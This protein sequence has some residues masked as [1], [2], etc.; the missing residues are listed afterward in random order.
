M[1]DAVKPY[2][3][4]A[5]TRGRA[6]SSAVVSKSIEL[7]DTA[8]QKAGVK[9]EDLAKL[10]GIPMLCALVA[11][12][13]N[14]ALLLAMGNNAW[15]KATALSAGQPFTAYLS[16][17]SVKFGTPMNPSADNKF[18]CASN[19]DSCEL[20]LLCSAPDDPAL[21][22]N[23]LPKNTPAEAW[24][25]AAKAGA[26]AMTFLSLGFVPGLAAAG[27]TFL[28]AAKDI[29]SFMPLILK[30][31]DMGFKLYWQK[32][33]IVGCWG[34]LWA[35]MFFSMLVYAMMIPDTLGWGLVELEASFGLLRFAFIIVSIFGAILASNLFTLWT[36]ENVIE[37]WME[38]T[39][40]KMFT[41]KKALYLELML[42]LALYLFMSISLVDWS[43]LLIVLAGYYLDAK[44]WNFLLMYLVL[45]AISI[46]FDLVHLASLPSFSNMTPGESF[47][48]SLWVVIF[49]LKP[50]I[51]CT[52][53]AYEKYEKPFEDGGGVGSY[54]TFNNE[55][56]EIAE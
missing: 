56:D 54:S 36:S 39:E 5:V 50:V 45:V 29:P 7:R 19:A 35:F 23:A 34:V 15:L 42:Q 53:Y 38:F 13:V 32:L 28:Y 17:L 10:S 48:A 26:A 16:L 55:N 9:P 40:A 31:E 25:S 27:A 8:L 11:L 47:G 22:P 24:C 46:L 43:G 30:I 20:G 21:F 2:I 49:L 3:E 37:A 4:M 52:I 41:A 1:A 14:V 51:V 44:R 33:I 18:F 12:L 6:V